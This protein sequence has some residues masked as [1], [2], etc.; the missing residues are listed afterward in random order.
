[1]N[2]M[3]YASHCADLSAH[4]G[5]A[6]DKVG[7]RNDPVILVSSRMRLEHVLLNEV[8]VFSFV[9][10]CVFSERDR[11]QLIAALV[12]SIDCRR[13]SVI[14]VSVRTAQ[15]LMVELTLVSCLQQDDV[16]LLGRT[17]ERV[18]RLQRPVSGSRT[19]CNG[20]RQALT[21][22]KSLRLTSISSLSS[23]LAMYA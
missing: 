5:R 8:E 20:E 6:D 18:Q 16:E 17:R 7:P 9:H 1:M 10:G 15:I 12:D 4:L 22:W 19:K 3:L 2:Q 13:M 14:V 11:R 21:F 23:S